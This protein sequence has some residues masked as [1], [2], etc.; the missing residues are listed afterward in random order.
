MRLEATDVS[1]RAAGDEPDGAAIP[2]G[3]LTVADQTSVGSRN[4]AARAPRAA[5]TARARTTRTRPASA[6]RSARS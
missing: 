5:T 6:P 4:L 2:L 1:P 3:A